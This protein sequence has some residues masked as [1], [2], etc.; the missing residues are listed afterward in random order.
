MTSNMQEIT[1]YDL[2]GSTNTCY[3]PHTW[4][5]RSVSLHVLSAGYS[6]HFRMALNYKKIAFKTIWLDLI[7]I[8]P[9][10]SKLGST[11]TRLFGQPEQVYLVP[12]ITHGKPPKLVQD[13]WDI[14]AYLD[15]TFPDTPQLIPKGMNAL[16]T[17][18]DNHVREKVTMAMFPLLMMP[19]MRF[20]SEEDHAYFRESRERWLGMKLEDACPPENR[21][22]QWKKVKDG[23]DGLAEILDKNGEGC[24]FVLGDRVSKGDMTL[25]ALFCWLE[26]LDKSAWETLMTWG[27]GRWARLWAASEDWRRETTD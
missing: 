1:L 22:A 17:M 12:V 3:S 7:N 16:L 5:A 6:N 25:L 24:F 26:K 19:T 15:A 13:S 10:L 18:Y 8:K 11:P 27:N 23:L 4:Q 9:T 2:A 21:E 20:I 14:I